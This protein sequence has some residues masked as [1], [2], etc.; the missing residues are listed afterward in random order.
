MTGLAL[1][2]ALLPAAC[3][4][5]TVLLLAVLVADDDEV[6]QR[7]H[8]YF[9]VIFSIMLV[10][11]FGFV[12]EPKVQQTL[13]PEQKRAAELEAHP[14]FIVLTE[15]HVDEP[16]SAKGV[17]QA[18]AARLADDRL[19]VP[20]AIEQVRPELERAGTERLGFAGIEQRIAWGRMQLA[21]LK[22]L[23]AVDPVACHG[24]I[25]GTAQG[26]A[27]LRNSVS[28]ENR[29]EF[30][31]V[32]VAML[33]DGYANMGRHTSRPESE[34]VEFNDMARR[35]GVLREQ[36]VARF[37]EDIIGA[38]PKSGRVPIDPRG[39]EATLCSARITQLT[40]VLAEPAPMASG[41]VDG[42]LR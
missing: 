23:A 38:L 39:K 24:M 20:E 11:A 22:E 30:Q 33:R 8:R 19:S 26:D 31:Q 16:P 12:R 35:F 36:W 1:A 42:L 10:A 32:L 14:V 17:R 7:L 21:T 13:D 40:D 2:G 6:D 41:L 15:A 3:A 18:L 5:F 29:R 4:L 37:G 25:F 27:A 28:A 34:R 9:M